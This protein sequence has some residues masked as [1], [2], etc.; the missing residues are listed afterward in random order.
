[1]AESI[2]V[3]SVFTTL[4]YYATNATLFEQRLL[5]Y[6]R[7]LE[8]GADSVLVFEY[9]AVVKTPSR[10]EHVTVAEYTVDLQAATVQAVIMRPDLSVHA[11]H[12]GSRLHEG[13]RPGSYVPLAYHGVET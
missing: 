5:R 2:T 1:V 7:T 13:A 4:K 9:V 3:T 12:A 8:C 6:A 10:F 11:P